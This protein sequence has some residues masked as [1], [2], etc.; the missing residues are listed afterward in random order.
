MDLEATGV[1]ANAN[2][3]QV[4]IVLIEDGQI[5][6]T[7]ETDVN[8]HEP[9]DS[10]IRDLTGLTDWR[11]QKAPD[12]S[13]VAGKIYDLLEDAIF[14]AHN[15]QFDANL[16]A[17][18]LFMEGFELRTPR[19]DTVE[20]AQLLYPTLEKHGLSYLSKELH[21]DLSQAHQALADAYATAQLF[22]KLQ[23]RVK[24][25]PRQTLEAILEHAD[26]L[27]YETR[28]VLDDLL[29][30]TKPH[31]TGDYL[32]A[33]GLLLAKWQ[34]YPNSLSLS[35]DFRTNMG[36]LDLDARPQQVHFAKK[37]KQAH[38]AGQVAF[39]QGETGLGKTYAYL[40]TLLAQEPDKRLVVALPTLLLQDQLMAQEVARISQTFQLNCLSL[41]SPRHY[42]DLA[43]FAQ[44]LTRQE[45][46]RLASRYK[47]QILV[48]LLESQTGDLG[49]L[50]QNQVYEPYLDGIRHDGHTLPNSPFQAVDVLVRQKEQL[51]QSRLVVT[52]H[53][54]LLRRMADD[55]AFLD[56]QILVIDE[57]QKF[58]QAL[59][60]FSRGELLL[61]D[62]VQN[63][64]RLEKQT[65]TLLT[66][67]LLQGLLHEFD[68]LALMSSHSTILPLSR[69]QVA[70]MRQHLS[71]LDLPE[72]ADLQAFF[73][74]TFS[75]FWLESLVTEQKRSL[76]L[77]N[78]RLD[79]MDL[80]QLLP[81]TTQTYVI[82]ATLQIS[83]SLS[84]ADLLGFPETTVYGL[85]ES[86]KPNQMIWVDKSMPPVSD[87]A[88]ED[89]VAM[90]AERLI[91]ISHLPYPMLVLFTSKKI[92]LAVS[93]LLESQSI[94]HLCQY[95][96]GHANHLKRRFEKQECQLLLGTGTFWE[97]VDFA[98]S[99]KLIE[100]IVRLPFDNPE[101][102]LLQKINRHLEKQGKNAFYAYSLPATILRLKQAMGRV[103]RSQKQKSAVLILDSRVAY[104]PYGKLIKE[105]LANQSPLTEERF[106]ACLEEIQT[107]LGH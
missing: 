44:T 92:L 90:V 99:K 93:D 94:K 17:E 3:I 37:I 57:G 1:G 49:E 45:D 86:Y 55:K 51:S 50:N 84:L 18:Q 36:L 61:L 78:G 15:V 80:S 74:A 24:S 14:V 81:A 28:M 40:L 46:N 103:N 83:P 10:H 59:E 72:L 76:L 6:D 2:I 4:G 101:D 53:A 107:Y 79:L 77:K 62:Q 21:L 42:I 52:N 95:K 102:Y 16:L 48:W 20:L 75:E 69:K 96:H 22:L 98:S 23:D 87:L 39:L 64:M 54:Y 97:G 27:I 9:L 106:E 26:A 68:Q 65:E 47:M 105:A 29:A 7:Y 56:G 31:L 71:E 33:G 30:E 104:K 60:D 67:R 58:F 73:G 5:T 66:K 19:V 25:L 63:L 8:P 12:F 43:K 38:Q 91:A 34:V 11:L 32:E 100:V 41:K 35:K 85:V 70:R 88:E 82:S 89:F 13:Q